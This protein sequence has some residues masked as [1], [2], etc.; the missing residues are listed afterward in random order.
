MKTY[1]Q[2]EGKGVNL[3]AVEGNI[4]MNI[5]NYRKF[6]K[7]WYNKKIKESRNIYHSVIFPYD[8][9]GNIDKAAWKLES[10]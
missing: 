8:F 4:N 3:G 2:V 10:T 9:I 5:M 1:N 6:S 7:N